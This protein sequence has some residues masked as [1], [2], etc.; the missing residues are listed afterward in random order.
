MTY[1]HTDYF[2]AKQEDKS[3]GFIKTKKNY[4]YDCKDLGINITLCL[5]ENHDECPSK[6]TTAYSN[7][8]I[9]CKCKCHKNYGIKHRKKV[10][11][12]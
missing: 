8:V 12:K 6:Y 2:N 11:K 3:F 7:L 9:N 5:T 4:D 10:D 1:N